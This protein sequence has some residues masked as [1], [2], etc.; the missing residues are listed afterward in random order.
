[1]KHVLC[2]CALLLFQ[3][4]APGQAPL[5]PSEIVVL[6]LGQSDFRRLTNNDNSDEEPE[7]SPDGTVILFDSDRAGSNDLYVMKADGSG[8]IRLTDGPAKEDHGTWSSDGSRIAYQHE[9]EG[10]TDVYVMSANGSGRRRLTDHGARDGWTDWS[11]D[12]KRIVWTRAD[13]SESSS[14]LRAGRAAG[15]GTCFDVYLTFICQALP[16]Q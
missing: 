14:A 9:L 5:P 15:C 4:P 16:C 13:C 6:T 2:F 12:G 8:L 11:P 10:N 7:W 1:M 3:V